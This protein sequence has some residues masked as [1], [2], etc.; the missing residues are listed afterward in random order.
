[1]AIFLQLT[2]ASLWLAC[3][4]CPK[5]PPNHEPSTPCHAHAERRK[6]LEQQL[7]QLIAKEGLQ[8]LA[9]PPTVRKSL[10]DLGRSLN[11]DPI[12]SGNRNISCASCHH[13]SLGSGD[14]RHL[15]LGTGAQ[16]LGA[17]R[18]GG[19]I[20][21]RNAPALFNLHGYETMFWDSRID[22]SEGQIFTPA[23]AQ[24][25]P[26]MWETMEFGIVSAQAMFPVTSHVEMRG[27]S[28]KNGEKG[29]NSIADAK[30][31]TEVWERLTARVLDIP[32]YR[33]ALA[34]AYPGQRDFTFA[35]IANALAAFQIDAYAKIN[36]PWQRYLQGDKRALSNR[37]IQ[38]ALTFFE[39]GCANCHKGPM[40]SDF[41]LHN[42]GLAAVGP[43]KGKGESGL[44]D[45]GRMNITGEA[46]DKH[47]FRTAPLINV[48]L[49]APY[50]HAGQFATLRG[51]IEHYLDPVN[52]L[53]TY[54]TF[55]HIG[56]SEP[57]LWFFQQPD[58]A[59]VAR[60]I[61]PAVFELSTPDVDE[62]MHFLSALTDPSAKDLNDL[63][64]KSVPSGL[65]IDRMPPTRRRC[66]KGHRG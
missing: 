50:G 46:S 29:E 55:H 35:H 64:P 59:E 22:Q 9:S 41:A 27:Q 45:W 14:G 54:D 43:G 61:D 36:T 56:M 51:Y 24:I 40:F 7:D 44:E 66:E 4:D 20:A 31:E 58:N 23:N 19:D 62:L 17:L 63:I 60:S 13:P 49:S 42:T 38:G 3:S 18:W 10:R 2:A 52:Q 28:G 47:R 34:A 8:P 39:S 33:R 37:Q 11:F 25:T 1:M 26:E 57:L 5:V 16:G 65:K 48:E 30:N 15:P 21:P 53:M 32:A 12:L 6:K